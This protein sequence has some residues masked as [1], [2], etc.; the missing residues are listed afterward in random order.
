MMP[1]FPFRV[2]LTVEKSTFPELVTA[3]RLFAR[4]SALKNSGVTTM[5]YS[6]T[7][8]LRNFQI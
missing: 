4:G 5:L 6:E 3:I 1:T 2:T 7:T 8:S